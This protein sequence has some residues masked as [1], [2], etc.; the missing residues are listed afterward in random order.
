MTTLVDSHVRSLLC[1]IIQYAAHAGVELESGMMD[2][3]MDITYTVPGTIMWSDID[4]FIT[5][6]SF[7]EDYL[8]FAVEFFE[9]YNDIM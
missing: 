3:V 8:S 4:A 5:L 1:A 2:V 7:D 6:N 9:G